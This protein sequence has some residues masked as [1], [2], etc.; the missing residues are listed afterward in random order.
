MQ[1]KV[2]P[3]TISLLDIETVS[4]ATKRKNSAEEPNS[5][6]RAK[7]DEPPRSKE[8]LTNATSNENASSLV[9]PTRDNQ[10]IA[11]MISEM[12]SVS[13]SRASTKSSTSD[14]SRL[15]EA[16]IEYGAELDPSLTPQTK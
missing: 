14:S 2:A 4:K 8:I 7:L 6:K 3:T 15:A 9:A 13:T 16:T 11:G 10:M 1:E 5:P 12:V